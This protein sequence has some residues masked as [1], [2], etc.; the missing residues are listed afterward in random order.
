MYVETS[1]M[2][3]TCLKNTLSVCCPS[4]SSTSTCVLR[5]L[6]GV[7]DFKDTFLF[8]AV[9]KFCTQSLLVTA[10]FNTFSVSDPSNP[11]ELFTGLYKGARSDHCCFLEFLLFLARTER[12]E[13]RL[14]LTQRVTSAPEKIRNTFK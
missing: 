5:S 6:K 10:R 4:V 11:D 3:F 14:L 2:T 9:F 1:E 13:C 7:S 8:P 12:N